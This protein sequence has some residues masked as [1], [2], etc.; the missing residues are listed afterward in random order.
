MALLVR[1]LLYLCFLNSNLEVSSSAI[2]TAVLSLLA[3]TALQEKVQL[4]H[5]YLCSPDSTAS[6]VVEAS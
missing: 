5:Y 6:F 4:L 3:D 2:A 1:A